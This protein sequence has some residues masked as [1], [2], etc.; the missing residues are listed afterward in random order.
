LE[1]DNTPFLSTLKN[2]MSGFETHDK[3]Q[4][5]FVKTNQITNQKWGTVNHITYVDPSYDFP[6]ELRAFGNFSFE[7]KD[8][9]NFWKN[10]VANKQEVLTDDVRMLI[11]DRLVGNIAASFA[12]KKVSY[13]E[14]DAKTVEIAKELDSV[15]KDDFTKLGLELT[16]FRIEDINFTEKTESFIEKVT[17]KSA[18]VA[19]INKTKNIDAEAM[20]NYSQLEKLDIA[21]TAAKNEGS[22]GDMM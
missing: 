13:N 1:T 12:H 17:T 5:Y 4:I 10:Y 2:F 16:D 21:K 7:I 3:A 9:E 11:V 19:A 15:T 8:V 22:A 20:D 14:I 18:D 6:V